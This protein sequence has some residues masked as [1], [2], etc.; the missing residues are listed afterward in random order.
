MKLNIFINGDKWKIKTLSKKK[1]TN[2]Y[3]KA[4]G[5]TFTNKHLIVIRD[6]GPIKE[7]ILHELFHAYFSYTCLSSTN[8]ISA[9]DFEEVMAEFIA[10]NLN[11]IQNS[12]K[13]IKKEFAKVKLL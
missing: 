11:K 12:Y 5:I 8:S 9:E 7:T 2:K 10:L 6:D 13:E 3:G 4:V 1:F